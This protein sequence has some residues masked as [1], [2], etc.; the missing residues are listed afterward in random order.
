MAAVDEHKDPYMSNRYITTSDHL[1]LYKKAIVV[2]TKNDRYDLTRSKCT[3]FYQ[4]LEDFVST[5]GF[6][7]SVRIVADRNNT[8]MPTKLKNLISSYSSINQFSME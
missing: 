7:A 2:L 1:K 5:F 8:Y 6:K 4:V 3:G